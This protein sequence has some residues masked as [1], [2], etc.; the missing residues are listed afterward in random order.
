MRVFRQGV[1]VCVI[2]EYLFT[3]KPTVSA[4]TDQLKPAAQKT[5]FQ[6]GAKCLTLNTTGT[7]NSIEN[8]AKKKLENLSVVAVGQPLE[9]AM[10]LVTV[11]E[12]S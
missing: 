9:A 5:L 10:G 8:L 6:S 2:L 4:V 12:C 1:L 7:T 11:R 3:D